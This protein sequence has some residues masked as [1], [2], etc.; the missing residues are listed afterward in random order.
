MPKL[1]SRPIVTAEAA[2]MN[3]TKSADVAGDDWM[4]VNPEFYASQ[5]DSYQEMLKN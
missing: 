1:V 3:R 5:L 4:V 2:K